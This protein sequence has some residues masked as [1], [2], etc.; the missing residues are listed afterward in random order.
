M[1][2]FLVINFII[3][4]VMILITLPFTLIVR[5]N[6]LNLHSNNI[7]KNKWLVHGKLPLNI[8]HGGA[9]ETYPENT[10]YAYDRVKD[11]DA[12]EI[13][14]TLTKD[15]KLITH[16]NLDLYIP[17]SSDL[18]D[19]ETKYFIREYNYDEILQTLDLLDYPLI[20]SFNGKSRDL[21]TDFKKLSKAEIKSLGLAPVLLSDIFKKYPNKKYI[22]EIKD[23][24]NM[25][26]KAPFLKNPNQTLINAYKQDLINGYIFEEKRDNNVYYYRTDKYLD[27]F[28]KKAVDNLISLLKKFNLKEN[29]LIASFDDKVLKYF[30][31]K[32]NYEY[33]TM[34]GAKSAVMAKLMG[35]YNIFG[36]DIFKGTSSFSLP[37]LEE[38]DKDTVK[39][40]NKFQFLA[41]D[42]IY[43]KDAKT[44]EFLFNLFPKGDF[45]KKDNNFKLAKQ[46]VDGL[47]KL[48]KS[49][50][51]WT[52]NDEEEMEYL[53]N[54]KVDGIIT[55][56]PILLD[57][58]LKKYK[59][60]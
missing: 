51:I 29:I 22:V 53:I 27:M 2:K 13:D 23:V 21:K 6:V 25:H 11:F 33:N 32:T 35:Y 39:I 36:F 43:F 57:K 30:N 41:K 20:R 59:E 17:K 47:H 42:L 4:I 58:V 24:F 44:N 16:H 55:D 8:P 28:Y 3:L 38:I 7:S 31:K 5:S 18:Y 54:L 50:I 14:V 19:S 1:K 12:F 26:I 49:V 46:I 52:V 56:D 34:A 40:A 45:L 10:L 60:K 15:E 37:L 48:G 9:K